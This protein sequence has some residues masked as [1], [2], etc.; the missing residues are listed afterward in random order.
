VYRPHELPGFVALMD[1]RPVGCVTVNVSD[2][3]C[4]IVTLNSLHPGRGIASALIEAVQDHARR[5][6]WR[7]IW[8]VTTNDNLDALRFYQRRGFVLVALRRNAVDAARQIK[9]QIPRVG[10]HGIPIRD[11]IELE[12]RLTGDDDGPRRWGGEG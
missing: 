3:A 10:M 6:G 8:V 9:P 1:E 12:M 2:R 4:E 11:E 5:A 7:R